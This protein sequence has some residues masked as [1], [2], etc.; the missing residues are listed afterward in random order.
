MTEE[1]NILRWWEESPTRQEVVSVTALEK[2]AE[3]GRGTFQ[4]FLKRRRGLPQQHLDSLVRLL[5][6]I[7]YRPVSNEHRLL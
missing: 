3:V 1:E 6:L 4:H 2:K 5:E 7:G